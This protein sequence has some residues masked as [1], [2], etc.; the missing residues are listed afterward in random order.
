MDITIHEDADGWSRSGSEQPRDEPI[1]II[2]DEDE[3]I[4]EDPVRWGFRNFLK[5]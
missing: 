2:Q 3:E 4:I 5:R 1:Y